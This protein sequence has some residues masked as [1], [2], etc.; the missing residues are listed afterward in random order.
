[1]IRAWMRLGVPVCL[2]IGSAAVAD[3][4][5]TRLTWPVKDPYC[6]PS[7]PS[8][9]LE[10]RTF[11]GCFW[12]AGRA[13]YLKV[14]S[15]DGVDVYIDGKKIINRLMRP[16]HLPDRFQSTVRWPARGFVVFRKGWHHI[17]VRYSNV[18]YNPS[19]G[20]ID[21]CTLIAPGLRFTACRHVARHLDDPRRDT[22]RHGNN[23]LGN[24]EDPPP[25]G[26]PRENDGE[27]TEPG[28][29]GNRR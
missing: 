29:P 25:P 10:V 28:N 1:M 21:G 16:Q 22:H 15:D 3:L 27:G 9:R 26:R 19:A 12:S 4:P 6:R 8:R 14:I 13:T 20:D 18:I 2:V 24:G 7:Y 5:V 17:V 23:G 11:S